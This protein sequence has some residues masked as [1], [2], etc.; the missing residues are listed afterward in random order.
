MDLREYLFRKR[1]TIRKF[2]K[3]I[4]YS[5]VTISSV[6]NGKVKAGP[7]LARYVEKAS[8]GEV[9]APELIAMYISK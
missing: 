8:G 3:Q 2:A 4:D 7:K 6:I 5:V 9:T 1:L